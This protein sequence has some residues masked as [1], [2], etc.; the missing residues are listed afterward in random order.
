M[1]LAGGGRG[2]GHRSGNRPHARPQGVLDAGVEQLTLGAGLAA[3]G[4]EASLSLC[5]VR[6]IYRRYG[7]S[8]SSPHHEIAPNIASALLARV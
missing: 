4:V 1:H 5:W 2:V 8:K 3:G 6:N 7:Q